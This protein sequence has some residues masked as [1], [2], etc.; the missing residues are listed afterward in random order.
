MIFRLPPGLNILL[1]DHTASIWKP[2]HTHPKDYNARRTKIVPSKVMHICIASF[3]KAGTSF[4]PR[5]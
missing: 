4:L 5:N 1:S 2:T 3:L